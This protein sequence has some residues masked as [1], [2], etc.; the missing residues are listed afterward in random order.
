LILYLMMLRS[1]GHSTL[2]GSI[3]IGAPGLM[4]NLAL[5]QIGRR[6]AFKCIVVLYAPRDTGWMS[7]SRWRADEGFTVPY[8]GTTENPR[9]W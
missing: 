3:L 6:D 2:C 1:L 5:Y 8:L 4:V 7:D 9:T